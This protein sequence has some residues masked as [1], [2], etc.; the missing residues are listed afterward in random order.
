MA[1]QTEATTVEAPIDHIRVL[2]YGNSFVK[3]HHDTPED[4]RAE[5][6]FDLTTFGSAEAFRLLLNALDL[7]TDTMTVDS[8]QASPGAEYAKV[9]KAPDDPDRDY[10]VFVWA[11][12][13]LALLTGNNPRTGEY[14]DP[15]MRQ[16]EKGYASYIGLS[17]T[18][19]AVEEAYNLIEER[20]THIKGRDPND[21][22]FI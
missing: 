11:N 18:P 22:Q 3:I 20:A 4:A 10:G 5:A 8:E 17:G 12:A 2:D 9:D 16:N 19:E 13:D 7:N 15:S 21:R 6:G 14:S 1:D